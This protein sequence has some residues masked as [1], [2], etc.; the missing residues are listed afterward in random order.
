MD[1]EAGLFA[2]NSF[3]LVRPDYYGYARSDGFFSTKN[4]IQTI[5]NTIQIFHDQLPLFSIYSGEE[6]T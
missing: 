2:K 3:D 4:C 5:Y 1:K 6:I